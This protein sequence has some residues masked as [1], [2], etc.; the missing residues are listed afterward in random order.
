MQE[1]N[2][3]LALVV[4]KRSNAQIGNMVVPYFLDVSTNG[5]YR[6]VEVAN[7]TSMKKEE[8]KSCFLKGYQTITNTLDNV[9]DVSI[10]KKFF[11]GD[12]VKLRRFDTVANKMA[13]ESI[14]L[15]IDE[16]TSKA[17]QMA[18]SCDMPIFKREEGYTSLYPQ[19]QLVI[20]PYL[21]KPRISFYLNEDRSLHY[22]FSI[23][24]GEECVFLH[25]KKI[26]VISE[27]PAILAIRNRIYRMSDV[28][29]P[30][31]RTFENTPFLKIDPSKVEPYM[32]AFVAKCITKYKVEVKGFSLKKRDNSNC[33]PIFSLIEDVMG[34]C[35]QLS[36]AY[37]D[38]IYNYKSF[39]KKVDLET[40]K[41][42]YS[43]VI[44]QRND[45]IEDKIYNLLISCGLRCRTGAIFEVD[46]DDIEA[47]SLGTCV[48]WL[49]NYA[50]Y[51]REWGVEVKNNSEV[52]RQLYID[53]VD[54]EVKLDEKIDWFDVYAVVHFD[55]FNIP[56][57]E[58][59][60]HIANRIP[61]YTLPNG[62]IFY[63]P[64]EW[65]STWGEIMVNL[66]NVKSGELSFQMPRTMRTL[67]RPILVM[68]DDV[69]DGNAAGGF[70]NVTHIER[71]GKLNATLRSYQEEGFQ[72]LVNLCQNASGG[73]L[74]DDMGLGKTLQTISVINHL[75]ATEDVE[76]GHLPSLIVV[77]VSLI[78]N[79]VNEVHRFAPELEIVQWSQ[80]KENTVGPSLF[81]YDI[82]IV[83]YRRALSDAKLLS[84]MQFRMLVIDE[85]QY[86]K[87]SKSQTYKAIASFKALH[88]LLLTGTPIENKLS[89][90]WAQMNIANPHL[91]GSEAAFHINYE[92]PIVRYSNLERSE[93][94]Q[95]TIAPYMLRRTK[96][97]VAKDLPSI[98]EQ[99]VLCAMSEEQRIIY[100]SEKSSSRNEVLL[101]QMAGTVDRDDVEDE[102]KVSA[103]LLILQALTRL[104]M[105]AIDPQMLSEYEDMKGK[106]GKMN[107]VLEHLQSAL[108]EGH[109]VLIFSSFVRDLNILASSLQEK[110]IIYSML[111]G[112]TKDRDEQITR[113][114]TDPR[115]GVFL[116]S[117]KA[118]GTGLN[119]TEA[120]YVFI[121]NPWWNPAVEAQAYA[122]AHRIG[123]QKPVFVYRFISQ[124]TVEEKIL[125]LQDTKKDLAKSFEATD[126]PF[127]VFG[128]E[129][130]RQ[131]IIE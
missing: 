86:I 104:R 54:L 93:K 107:V 39:Q 72:W 58:F 78:S 71:Q 70:S 87:N 106:S 76:D 120:D 127:E 6:L 128:M 31:M 103:S 124:D 92:L 131:L 118:G 80:V 40:E 63:I 99:I 85:S 129:T 110:G 90:L 28:D 19:D 121:L 77:P 89:D 33:R 83:S 113:F 4:Q 46:T 32:K 82:I 42:S 21:S 117:I 3:I 35:F 79:W 130:M 48:S 65:F 25:R 69:E 105:I 62:S 111:T 61:T 10:A 8:Y 55:G 108:D 30:M 109:K 66:V 18:V 91:L 17:I 97:K 44:I 101:A 13:Y 126:N 102:L 84:Q 38:K 7:R 64:Q 26:R 20:N 43:M 29:Y 16:A 112:D 22:R 45:E 37:G 12:M 56:F 96:E 98:T 123:Q 100:E 53:S 68:A 50:A 119:L 122:R 2:V 51:L 11:G 59:R 88:R 57:L 115:C 74:A 67:L 36:F 114:N 24:E 9:S 75:Y 5:V 47:N 125:R 95:S 34:H 41:D 116:L 60:N 1:N 15:F 49:N 94:L 52:S 27:R 23:W 81:K 14:R 73:I